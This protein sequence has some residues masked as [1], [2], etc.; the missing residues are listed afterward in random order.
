M[1]QQLRPIGGTGANGSGQEACN[2]LGNRREGRSE[3]SVGSLFS[4]LQDC[5]LQA[6]EDPGVHFARLYRLELQLQQ[7]RCALDDY[8][9]NTSALSGLAEEYI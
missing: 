7:V 6:G 1:L 4:E 9:L 2:L 8:Q 3:A 5:T